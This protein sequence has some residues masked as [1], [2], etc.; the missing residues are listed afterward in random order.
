MP[1]KWVHFAGRA[2]TAFAVLAIGIVLSAAAAYWTAK[3]VQREVRL[4]FE[5]A[6]TDAQAAIES[7]IRAYSD[8]LLG[9]RGLFIASDFVSRGEFRD[10]IDSLGL[11][12][13]Y[14]GIQG[15]NYGQRISASEE[16]TFVAMARNDTSVDSRGYPGFAIKPPG[17]RPEYVVVKM[18][19]AKTMRQANQKPAIAR[20]GR[21]GDDPSEARND[22]PAST[23]PSAVSGEMCPIGIP[24]ADSATVMPKCSASG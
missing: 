17:N 13:R 16:R 22:R 12:R 20:L 11:S 7:R 10:Y 2:S 21:S 19:L 9:V 4:K 5:S 3:Q 6:V 24:V 15:I 23:K 14:P 1:P 18:M 8:V